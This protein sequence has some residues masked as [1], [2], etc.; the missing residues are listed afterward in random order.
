MFRMWCKILKENRLQKDIVII[1]DDPEKNR[2]KKVLDG[3]AKACHTFDLA[4]PI[5][6]DATIEDFRRHDKV[7]FGQD[8]FVET[9]PFDY[10]EIH[11]IEEDSM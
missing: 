5:W 11:V 2:T 6:F 1:D 9:V 8:N 4:Q 3:L 7:R 10:L